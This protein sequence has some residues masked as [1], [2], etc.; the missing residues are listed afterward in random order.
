MFSRVLTGSFDK[1]ARIWSLDDSG[2]CLCVMRG[3]SGEIVAIDINGLKQTVAT[4][5]MDKS[6][7]LFSTATGLPS[8]FYNYYSVY[9]IPKCT[10]CFTSQA[11]M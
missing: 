10:H 6:T 3:H 4:S 9:S 5:S 11:K 1:T 7:R 2:E 8:S